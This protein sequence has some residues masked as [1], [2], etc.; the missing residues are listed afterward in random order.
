[1]RW[2]VWILVLLVVVTSIFIIFAYTSNQTLCDR[3]EVGYYFC[4]Y[5]LSINKHSDKYCEEMNNV[6]DWKTCFDDIRKEKGPFLRLVTFQTISAN[7]LCFT[8][9]VDKVYLPIN[10]LSSKH[11]ELRRTYIEHQWIIKEFIKGE[12]F[13]PIRVTLRDDSGII[14][15]GSK[16]ER[17]NLSKQKEDWYEPVIDEFY[18]SLPDEFKEKRKVLYGVNGKVTKKMYLMLL[19]DWRIEKIIARRAGPISI[20]PDP[21]LIFP[22]KDRLIVPTSITF[23]VN[24]TEII[25][26]VQIEN[27]ENS[28]FSYT[29]KFEIMR[30]ETEGT[31]GLPHYS[32]IEESI[33][34]NITVTRNI[35]IT[36]GTAVSGSNYL[37]KLTIEM[38]NGT[39]YDTNTFFIKI[40]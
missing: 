14:I 39:I 4:H 30:Q 16:E 24:E 11:N 37:C 26:P 5:V 40:Q 9:A 32:F 21:I 20:G 23:M 6:Q 1:M 3:L 29:M 35:T 17:R 15:E 25:F 31:L 19:F 33:G 13:V 28:S 36:R 38:V 18:Q 2:F 10:F 27:F 8:W 12:E 7:F 22:S 34:P